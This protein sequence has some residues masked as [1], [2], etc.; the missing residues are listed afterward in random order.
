MTGLFTLA[1]PV[2]GHRQGSFRWRRSGEGGATGQ[3]RA[4]LS[5]ALPAKTLSPG[6]E[7]G[8]IFCWCDRVAF[9]V[10]QFDPN[11]FRV[12]AC[13]QAPEEVLHGKSDSWVYLKEILEVFDLSRDLGRAIHPC[14][15]WDSHLWG[16]VTNICFFQ[17]FFCVFLLPPSQEQ[18]KGITPEKHLKVVGVRWSFS[19]RHYYT[20]KPDCFLLVVVG[21]TFQASLYSG[22]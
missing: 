9:Y 10:A 2:R 13:F 21:F 1:H 18:L 4:E 12:I 17:I 20:P 11:S 15:P 5:H 16:E 7:P 6:L 22:V 19:L 8:S 14:G 3:E